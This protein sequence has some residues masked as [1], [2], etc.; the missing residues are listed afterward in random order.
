[1]YRAS[2]DVDGKAY[3][4]VM[5][6]IPALREEPFMTTP[7]DFRS[8][9]RFELAE[10]TP[11]PDQIIQ[12]EY[13]GETIDVARGFVE[14][15]PIM[16]TWAD[17]AGELLE[18]QR[19]G[20]QLDAPRAVRE[21]TSEIV[22]G[23]EDPEEKLKAI[24]H[25]VQTTIVWNKSRGLFADKDLS[26]V[27]STSVADGPEIALLLTAM[28]REAGLTAHPVIISTRSHGKIEPHYPLTSQFNHVLTY[29]EAGESAFLVDG[30]DPLRPHYLLPYQALNGTGLVILEDPQWIDIS[31]GAIQARQV[32]VIAQIDATGGVTG[33]LRCTD[34]GYSALA[35]RHELQ[36]DGEEAFIRDSILKDLPEADLVE[37]SLDG[38]EDTDKPVKSTVSFSASGVG[39]AVGD[40]LYVNPMLMGRIEANPFKLQERNFPVDLGYR[41]DHKYTFILTLPEGY[42]VQEQPPNIAVQLPDDAGVYMRVVEA[43]GNQMTVLNRFVLAKP[44][45]EPEEYE[46]LREFYDRVV[47]AQAQQVV[48]K[49]I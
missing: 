4:W 6:D 39:Q 18:S 47:A 11:P 1:M 12:V 34:K 16:T 44:R 28:F 35:S 25:F 5:Q 27:L 31:A 38:A 2:T 36:E 33:Q 22:A 10:I 42:E 13:E 9:I 49:R 8:K 30:T 15:T 41:R 20:Q 32:D 14:S 7:E 19:F 37:F 43:V 17:L 24:Y 23:I 3:R 45:Y 21:K 29:V 26:E 48:L 40:M 46:A